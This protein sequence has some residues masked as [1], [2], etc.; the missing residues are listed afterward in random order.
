MVIIFALPL[1]I[2][3]LDIFLLIFV[4]QGDYFQLTDVYKTFLVKKS[5]ETSIVPLISALLLIIAFLMLR[6]KKSIRV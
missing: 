2:A 4:R 3:I 6:K 5:I 1:V